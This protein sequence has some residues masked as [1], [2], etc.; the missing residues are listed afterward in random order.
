MSEK[1][2]SLSKYNYIV[3]RPDCVIGYNA[4]SG[5]FMVL[6]SSTIDVLEERTRPGLLSDRTI[7][8]LVD[9]GFLIEGNELDLL[10]DKLHLNKSENI[11]T[12]IV[13]TPT[14]ACN[15]S[16]DYCFQ[17]ESR[18]SNLMTK[19]VFRKSAEFIAY[20]Q[21]NSERKLNLTWFGG[22]PLLARKRIFQFLEKELELMGADRENLTQ[23]IITNGVLLDKKT[24]S[25][26]LSLGIRKAQITYDSEIY[27][28]GE[29]RGVI[30]KDKSLSPI[31]DGILN[32]IDA[33]MKISIRIN[34]SSKNSNELDNIR[35]R[36]SEYQLDKY[37]Y[38]A[39]IENSFIVP[40]SPVP[41]FRPKY[42]VMEHAEF[43]ALEM[44][45]NFNLQNIKLLIEQLRPITY[46]CGA[47]SGSMVVIA[48]NGDISRCWS[49][50]GR[51]DEAIC[52]IL[53]ADSFNKMKTGSNSDVWDAYS[54]LKYEACRNCRVLP[55]CMGGCAYCK[56]ANNAQQP[57]CTPVKY[58][59]NDL[60]NYIGLR[61]NINK[62]LTCINGL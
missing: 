16:C 8:I 39:R 15:F 5:S 12:Q 59:I 35:A 41:V 45:T 30:K 25:K 14:L 1:N 7:K 60:V 19:D 17:N 18:I 20:S 56:V 42:P 2:L 26:C 23:T 27:I 13:I 61:L 31:T 52:N 4:N 48:P 38:N 43:A 44:R 36:L 24:I 47:T 9:N 37:A 6:N 11:Y 10:K 33:G 49:S 46:F 53:D 32:A 22:E 40:D 28:Q 51:K 58:Y 54:P 21:K 62:G 34:V 29:R 55:L 3:K 50:A 57:S